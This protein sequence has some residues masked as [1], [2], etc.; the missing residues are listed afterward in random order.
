M[1]REAEPPLRREGDGGTC[2]G[3]NRLKRETRQRKGEEGSV[4][5][6]GWP[7]VFWSLTA[8]VVT[9]KLMIGKR[10]GNEMWK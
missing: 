10:R 9:D 7:A 2:A 6:T 3:G 5:A 4:A 8:L 1:P